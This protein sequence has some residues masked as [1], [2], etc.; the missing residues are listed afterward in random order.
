VSSKSQ[1]YE[2]AGNSL[3]LNLQADLETSP[4]RHEGVAQAPIPE[5]GPADPSSGEL[6]FQVSLADS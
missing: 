6:L 3:L 4:E 1:A 5:A 2:G